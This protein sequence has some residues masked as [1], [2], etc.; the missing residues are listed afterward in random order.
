MSPSF[1]WF[2]SVVDWPGIDGVLVNGND[3]Y[4]LQ[5]TIAD[6][7]RGPRDGLK[8]VWQTIGADVA[9]LFTWHFV[10]VTDNKDL[11][12]KHTTDF[13]TRLDDVALGRRPHVKVLAWVCVPKSDV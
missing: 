1:Y 7:H 13:G 8:K 10:V 11:A 4:A 9:R 3:I 5:A 6:T 2:P 12:D